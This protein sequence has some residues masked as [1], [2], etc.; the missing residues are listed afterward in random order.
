M[1]TIAA[2]TMLFLPGTFIATL[3]GMSFFNYSKDELTVSRQ[4]WIYV[5]VT[6]PT[7]FVLFIIWWAYDKITLFSVKS[8]LHRPR[9]PVSRFARMV[10]FN[11]CW[12][13]GLYKSRESSIASERYDMDSM[14]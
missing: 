13:F 12:L 4:W 1:K 2:L 11:V 3:F 10:Y 8:W 6:I 5:A 14:V 7:T 9:V